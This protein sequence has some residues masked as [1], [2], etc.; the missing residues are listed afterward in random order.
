[1]RVALIAGL[2][3]VATPALADTKINSVE[4]CVAYADLALVASTLAKHGINQA[5]TELMIPDMYDMRSENAQQIARRIV[6]VAYSP[7][8][9]KKGEP[10][11]FASAFGNMCVRTGGRID[12]FLGAKL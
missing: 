7:E 8:L 4:E 9:S 5:D 10:R 11:S 6:E 12:A 3:L 1:M 2:M